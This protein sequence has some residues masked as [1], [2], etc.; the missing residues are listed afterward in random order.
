LIPHTGP[1]IRRL[2]VIASA[3][4]VVAGVAV[5]AAQQ[6]LGTVAVAP[7]PVVHVPPRRRTEAPLPDP[8]KILNG[9]IERNTTLA[10]A[11]DELIPRQTVYAIVQAARPVYDLARVSV[12]HPFDLTLEANGLLKVFTYGIDEI[13]TLRVVRE[14]DELKA[15]VV[16]RPHEVKSRTLTGVVASS[17]FGAVE[18]AGGEDQLALDMADVFNC[19]VDFN[20]EV[21]RGDTFRVAVETTVVD[22]KVVRW[23]RILA[24]EL[25]NAGRTLQAVRFTSASGEGYYAPDGTPMRRAFLRSPLKFSRVS[26][27]FTKNRFHPVLGIFRPHLGVDLAAPTGTPVHTVGDGVVTLAGW[28]G[29]F[30][31]TVKVHHPNGYDTLYGH[32]SRILVRPGQRLT[33]GS[34]LGLVG[35]TG[36]AT[37]PHLDYRMQRGGVFLDPLRIVSPPAEPIRSDERTAFTDASGRALALL[38]DGKTGEGG[39]SRTADLAP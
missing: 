9:T 8:L 4:V 19:H 15:D 28:S 27:G 23:G 16:T 2:S 36:V 26:S 6:W 35:A 34:L 21:Q 14:G 33:Q 20:T 5:L 10:G 11:L 12:G 18:D 1:K 38:E 25:V 29:G 7:S 30:G 37:G 13:R 24:A 31:N 32:L 22:G 3:T 17:L 39:V